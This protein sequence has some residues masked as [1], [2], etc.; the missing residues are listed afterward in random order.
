MRSYL[1]NSIGK[2]QEEFSGYQEKIVDFRNK[3]VV[4]FD[5]NYIH[6][7]VPFYDIAHDSAVAL[8]C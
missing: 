8:H 3:W 7:A 5:P 1:F 6:P 2:T 4:H